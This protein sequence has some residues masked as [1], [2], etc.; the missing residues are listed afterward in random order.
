[1]KATLLLLTRLLLYLHVKD[2]ERYSIF[3]S[4]VQMV[5]MD[6]MD[7]KFII[8]VLFALALSACTFSISYDEG[9][10][11]VINETRQVSNFDELAFTGIGTLYITMG[12]EELLEIE[13]EDN[14]LPHIVTRVRGERLEIGFD[15]DSWENVI[16][17]TE[18]IRY[19][20][21]VRTLE[22]VDLSGLGDVQ[23]DGIEADRLVLTLSGAGRVKASGDV[24][25]QEINV[26][27]AGSY[28]GADLRSERIDVN[29]SG[30]GSA[31][32]WAMDFLNV[33]I[34]GL[35]NVRYYGDPEIRETVTGLGNLESLGER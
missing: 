30:A 26:T 6:T 3:Q 23:L 14:I 7:K 12:D 32:V 24:A 16:R 29:L 10:G 1:M 20:V 5:R 35:G 33:N 28:D 17:P 31:T 19:F 8:F 25:A 2:H 9:S 34:S 22:Q 13:A 15:N 11:V 21:T 18:P 4:D 27:G